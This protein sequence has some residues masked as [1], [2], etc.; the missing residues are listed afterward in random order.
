LDKKIA[1]QRLNLSPNKKYILFGA[2][3]IIKDKNKGLH[4]LKSSLE[5]IYQDNL[6]K[7]IEVI[8]FGKLEKVKKFDLKLKHHYLGKIE[9]DK[10]LSLIYSAA[11]VAVMPSMLENLPNIIM[12]SMACGTPCVAFNTGGIP[13]LVDHKKNGFIAKPFKSQ[14][15]KRGILWILQNNQRLKQL[16][17]NSRKKVLDKF[18]NRKI[19]KRHQA[20]YSQLI[21]NP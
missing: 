8:I 21:D 16:S 19:A 17:D 5:K 1:R 7:K 13:D 20:L 9:N 2:G 6:I 18:D 14:D 4:F 3:N 15:F 12:E 10:K 11:D